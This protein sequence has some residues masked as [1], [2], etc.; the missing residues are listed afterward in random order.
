MLASVK[1]QEHENALMNK[2]EQLY[3]SHDWNA[4]VSCLSF[5]LI[6]EGALTLGIFFQVSKLKCHFLKTM[7]S[8]QGTAAL[9]KL[10]PTFSVGH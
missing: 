4:C 3:V 9:L 7:Q 1:A 5:L 6:L 8:E 10:F 2:S